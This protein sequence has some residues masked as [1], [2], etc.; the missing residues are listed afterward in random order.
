MRQPRQAGQYFAFRDGLRP[1]APAAPAYLALPFHDTGNPGTPGRATVPR[2]TRIRSMG[3]LP[4][5][6]AAPAYLALPFHDTGNPGAP[7]RA[8]VPRLP[9]APTALR[10]KAS[11]SAPPCRDS[12]SYTSRIAPDHLRPGS[13]DHRIHPATGFRFVQPS[14]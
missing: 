11:P 8:T 14:G 3:I 5:A 1:C 6:P 12:E 2:Q 10:T 9:G 7:G 13:S 4:M